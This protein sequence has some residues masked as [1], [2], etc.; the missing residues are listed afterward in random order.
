MEAL[1]EN[2]QNEIK[3]S[4]ESS[5][6]HLSQLFEFTAFFSRNLI[7]DP[8]PPPQVVYR[9]LYC[10]FTPFFPFLLHHA[11][12]ESK[13]LLSQLRSTIL[14]VCFSFFF[15]FLPFFKHFCFFFSSRNQLSSNSLK[16]FGKLMKRYQNYFFCAI[17]LL[18][19]SFLSL[20]VPK[21]NLSSLFYP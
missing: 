10:I 2:L 8:L 9:L 18:I 15:P 4:A 5:V 21:L 14:I 11:S 12:T 19:A 16:S 7:P 3:K 13:F 17:S 6:D 1:K 20:K